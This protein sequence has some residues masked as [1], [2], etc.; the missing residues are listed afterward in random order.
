M[1]DVSDN[2]LIVLPA[3]DFDR[4]LAYLDIPAPANEQL[5]ALYREGRVMRG[6]PLPL[7]QLKR[8]MEGLNALTHCSSVQD[9]V[10]V[11]SDLAC[12]N[13]QQAIDTSRRE[14]RSAVTVPLVRG[15]SDTATTGGDR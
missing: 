1:S 8:N 11:Q 4:L 3:E 10:A 14:P 12:G 6:T 7:A 9:I 2:S 13:L 5:K 15:T